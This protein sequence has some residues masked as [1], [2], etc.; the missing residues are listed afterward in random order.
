MTSTDL[1]ESKYAERSRQLMQIARNL[2]DI[3]AHADFDIPRIAVIGGQS[4]GKSSLVEAVS[5]PGQWECMIFLRFEYDAS[6]AAVSPVDKVP[7]GSALTSVDDVELALRRAQ[8]AILNYPKPSDPFLMKT[9]DELEYYRKPEAFKNGTLK[10]SKNVV[11][12][13]IFDPDCGNLSFVDLPGLIQNDEQEVV[14]LVED[15]VMSTIQGK[16]NRFCLILV[17]IP[18]SDD[19]E[20]Q[21]AMRLALDADKDRSR[22]IG[23][24]TK[25]DTL[26]SGAIGARKKWKDLITGGDTPDAYALKHGYYCVKLPD[27]AERACNPSRPERNGIENTFFSNTIP[28][29]IVP[30]RKQFG[31][32]NLVTDLSKLL[33]AILDQELPQLRKKAQEKL[34]ETLAALR[35]LPAPLLADI[36]SEVLERLTNFCQEFYGTIHGTINA[37]MPELQSSGHT[38]CCGKS[39][40]HRNRAIYEE[41]KRQIR[42][43]APDFRPFDDHKEYNSP[44]FTD[45]E[46]FHSKEG[47]GNGP[48]DLTYVRRVIKESK[49]WELPNNV[50][51]DAKHALIDEFTR[52]WDVPTIRCFEK[53]FQNLTAC[54]NHILH[55]HFDRFQKL[56]SH[57]SDL[58]KD[59]VDG[60][61]QIANSFILAALKQ[62]KH[63][64]YTQ[65]EYYF[66]TLR[67]HWLAEYTEAR[68]KQN[69][70]V[71]L[72]AV[73]ASEFSDDDHLPIQLA[74]SSPG[75]YAVPMV[76]PSPMDCPRIRAYSSPKPVPVRYVPDATP[77]DRA[78]EALRELGYKN[79]TRA[80]LPRLLTAPDE[81]NEELIVMADVR[82]YFFVAYKRIVDN[83]PLAIE[84]ALNQ[85]LA[86][87]MK[88]T[89]LQKLNLG[90]ADAAKRLKELM[91]E[92]PDIA[93]KREALKNEIERLQ[94]I[95]AEI[96]LLLA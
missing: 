82:A 60:H 54:L 18:M 10:F 4:A 15:L 59:I 76:A 12:V 74:P 29:S 48:R 65:N 85:G 32:A 89:L 8:A 64:L 9:R 66:R 31:V 7:F 24:L 5:G 80:D 21:R 68:L 28:W 62:E 19:M 42:S 46:Q 17:T 51:F 63:P 45:S 6:G 26:T 44:Q 39:F 34:E 87:S 81:F 61:K 91:E 11:V 72:R 22:T 83:V 75:L 3:G 38:K 55:R 79:V 92:D 69:K 94:K 25:P 73:T 37:T 95:E 86:E 30:D 56:N 71:K 88:K 96:R 41:F 53:A 93:L 20:N 14:R 36:S 58:V 77:M 84:H 57:M 43:T 47:V 35:Q 78:L 33:T 23:V 52:E 40:I 16:G 2:R 27:D 13:D 90:G 49:T 67:L 70:Y 1:S 50:P